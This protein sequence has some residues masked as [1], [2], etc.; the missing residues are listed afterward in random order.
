MKNLS[1]LY[2]YHCDRL[3][4]DFDLRN[5]HNLT[6]VTQSSYVGSSSNPISVLFPEG[7][8]IN[9]IQLYY[10]KDITLINPTVITP[11]NVN[12]TYSSKLESIHFVN[13]PNGKGFSLLSKIMGWGIK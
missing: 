2:F 12:A 13:I 7:S 4:L 3:T 5:N 8:K 11:N 9:Y 10:P 1:I 6:S